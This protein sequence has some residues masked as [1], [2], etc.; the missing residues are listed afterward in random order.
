ML[1]IH[2]PHHAATTWRDFF[3]HIATIVLGLLIAI[4][5]EQTVELVHRHREAREA[6]ENIKQEIARN[7]DTTR[8]DLKRL[9]LIHKKLAQDLDLLNNSAPDAQILAQLDYQID[10]TRRRDSAW[11]A[12]KIDGSL[13][14]I[15]SDEIGRVSYFYG[16]VNDL[17]PI[18]VAFLSQLD[19]A[20]ALLEHARAAGKLTAFDRQQL[21]SLSASAMGAS[22]FISR[23]FGYEL[24]ALGESKLQ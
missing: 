8:S 21:E 10:F 13:A 7:I 23:M 19:S 16:T 17:E 1:D 24:K 4:G 14:L 22:A 11:S 20:Q 5:L 15:P 12:A 6:R 9:D 18:V 3:I 2:P